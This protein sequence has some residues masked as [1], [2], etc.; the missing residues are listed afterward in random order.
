[1]EGRTGPLTYVIKSDSINFCDAQRLREHLYQFQA[2]SEHLKKNLKLQL[3]T[4][5]R[6][7]RADIPDFRSPIQVALPEDKNPLK[8]LNVE[9][10]PVLIE[11]IKVY[12]NYLE[13]EK[14]EQDLNKAENQRGCVVVKTTQEVIIEKMFVH[15]DY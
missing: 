6:F 15:R 4:E 12:E 1:M 7:P 8:M 5:L 3:I 13:R 2:M 9:R 11:A 10:D 14:R